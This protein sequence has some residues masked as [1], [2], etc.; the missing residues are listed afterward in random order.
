MYL[1]FVRWKPLFVVAVLLFASLPA[2]AQFAGAGGVMAPSVLPAPAFGYGGF[3]GAGINGLGWGTQW[4]QN[5]YEGYLNGAANLTTANAQYQ[6]TIQQAKLTRQEV[7]RSSLDTRKK[8]LEERQYELSLQPDPEQIRQQQMMKSLNRSRNN[9]PP[10][11]IWAGTALNDLL[12]AIQTANS[13][14][15]TGPNV[16]IPPDVL[17]H[18]NMTTGTTYGGIGLLRDDGK[19]SWPNVLR[20]PSFD[21]ERKE[22]DTQLLEAVKAAHSGPV[23][24]NLTRKIDTT[25]KQL[26]QA[27]DAQVADLTPSEFT[28][29]SRYVRELKDSVKVLKQ[30]DVSKYFRTQWTPQGSTVADLVQQ[31]TREGLRFAPAVSG[32]ESYY[33]SLHRALVDYDMGV[34]QLTASLPP[35]GGASGK[36]EPRP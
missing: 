21:T 33:T 9:P 20:Q 4:M 31:M 13:R 25:V 22:L 26:E 19:L 23:E 30:N 2:R 34:T 18:V 17:K 27:I 5:P 10:T 24:Y 8:T 7:K 35:P 3:G 28:E 32:D 14:G 29:S 12:R 1:S 15:I 36:T 11:E 6:Q 16:P